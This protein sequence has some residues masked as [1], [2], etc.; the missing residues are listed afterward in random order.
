MFTGIIEE[1][2]VLERMQTMAGGQRLN[3]G[4]PGVSPSLREG[5]SIAVDGVCQTVTR[6]GGQ[7]FTIECLAVSLQKTTLG[8]LRPG[9]RVN[10][11]RALPA[12]GRLDGHIV[13]GH[14][15]GR[16]TIISLERRGD[17]H[18]LGLALPP[19]LM[20]ACIPEGSIAVNGVSLTIAGRT[21][22]NLNINII[23][24]TWNHTA[25]QFAQTG[26]AVNIETDI[27]ARYIEHFFNLKE[28]I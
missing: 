25:F 11:E 13:Q 14:V 6:C 1:I 2:A 15:N 18:Y 8:R 9:A 16:G 12:D 17:N 21:S 7:G 3:I 19:Q 10:L 23:P 4:A 5:D 28:N 24:H 26:N 22:E 27:F 20:R